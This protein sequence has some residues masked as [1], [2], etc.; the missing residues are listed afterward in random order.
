MR[1]DNGKLFHDDLDVEDNNVLTGV[2][3]FIEAFKSSV[4][5]TAPRTKIAMEL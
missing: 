3:K 1:A 4:K 5:V 2:F